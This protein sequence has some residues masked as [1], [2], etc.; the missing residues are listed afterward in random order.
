[1][2]S[3]DRCMDE[4]AAMSKRKTGPYYESRVAAHVASELNLMGIDWEIDEVGNIL[5][6]YDGP[7]S[8]GKTPVALV[9]HMD[10]PAFE[11]VDP[12]GKQGRLLGNVNPEYFA[13]PIRVLAYPAV[14]KSPIESEV[15]CPGVITGCRKVGGETLLDLHLEGDCPP[16]PAFG[17]WDFPDMDIRGDIV[18]LRAAD[19][20]VGCAVILT[21]LAE[22]KQRQTSAKIVGVFT[23]AEEINF[24]GSIHIAETVGLPKDAVVVS[25]ETSKAIPGAEIG[26]GPVIRTGDRRHSFDDD[27]ESL[28]RVAAAQL[29]KE[30]S[31]F[32]S[33]R[34]LM[35]GGTCEGSLYVISGYRT[36][37]MALPLGNYHNMSPETILSPEYISVS[38]MAAEVEILLRASEL[39]LDDCRKFE[40]EQLLH[41]TEPEL[42][43]LRRLSYETRP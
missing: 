42:E 35:N 6:R 29:Q 20:P 21:V 23:R 9:A 27:A 31:A 34:Q 33:Q 13:S 7:E 19:D 25:L 39:N 26:A 14:P 15:G 37:A 1:L 28:L 17:V 41:G 32:R 2:V 12:Q 36:T 3:I 11:I 22:A 4:L 10:H 43:K 40:R 8:A 18:H 30:D 24:L 16:L 38:D 5:A